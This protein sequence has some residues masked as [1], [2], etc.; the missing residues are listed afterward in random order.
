MPWPVSTIALPRPHQTT[1]AWQER[2]IPGFCKS[3]RSQ[4]RE[5]GTSVNGMQWVD[6]SIEPL[7]D[8]SIAICDEF[9]RLWRFCFP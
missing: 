8:P 3:S 5:V 9:P 4:K 1:G 6:S 2:P 7:N